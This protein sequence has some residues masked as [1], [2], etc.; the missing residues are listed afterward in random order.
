MYKLCISISYILQ[1]DPAF[2]FFILSSE[3][4]QGQESGKIVF[5]VIMV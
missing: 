5:V 1:F 4:S 3:T 2:I